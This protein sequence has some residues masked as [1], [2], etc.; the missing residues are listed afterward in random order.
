MKRGND[1]N[2]QRKSR[3]GRGSSFKRR[4]YNTTS[5]TTEIE[6][7]RWKQAVDHWKRQITTNPPR[8]A[9]RRDGQGMQTNCNRIRTNCKRIG[10]C[11]NLHELR[12]KE[13]QGRRSERIW[14]AKTRNDWIDELMD[15]KEK[16]KLGHKC[17]KEPHELIQS[18]KKLIKDKRKTHKGLKIACLHMSPSNGH[19]KEAN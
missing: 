14:I 7:K 12:G 9:K 2:V 19:H 15:C 6:S 11:M 16:L 8:R 10:I 18:T 17:R 13:L 5:H 1:Q 4:A 3:Q